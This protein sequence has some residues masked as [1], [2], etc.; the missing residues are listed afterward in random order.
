MDTIIISSISI[1]RVLLVSGLEKLLFI[2]ESIMPEEVCLTVVLKFMITTM[3]MTILHFWW[4]NID[5][6]SEIFREMG[7]N[8]FGWIL[9]VLSEYSELLLIHSSLCLS[10]SLLSKKHLSARFT[11]LSVTS[12]TEWL[13]EICFWKSRGFFAFSWSESNPSCFC[14]RPTCKFVRDWW[15]V[16]YQ[17]KLITRRK[18]FFQSSWGR[19]C[20][21]RWSQYNEKHK[22]WWC[23]WFA[24]KQSI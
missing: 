17:D 6:F 7:F 5:A 12:V 9:T 4:L 22:S 10:S 1:F 24:A 3:V 2:T 19:D 15:G 23:K 8:V 20:W 13:G 11:L 18:S 16:F 14:F 21:N